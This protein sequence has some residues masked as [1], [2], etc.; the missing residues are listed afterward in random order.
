M[1]EAHCETK[2]KLTIPEFT[3]AAH[4]LNKQHGLD[5]FVRQDIEWSLEAQSEDDS[6]LEWLAVKVQDCY[7]QLDQGRNRL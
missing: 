7:D 3:L 6:Q 1:Q 4:V 2:E 5:T